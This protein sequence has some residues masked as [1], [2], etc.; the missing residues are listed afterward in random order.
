MSKF[1]RS[2]ESIKFLKFD[3]DPL[4]EYYKIYIYS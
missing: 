2:R 4:E 3:K 1:D